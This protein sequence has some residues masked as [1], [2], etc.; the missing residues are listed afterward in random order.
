MKGGLTPESI[1]AEAVRHDISHIFLHYSTNAVAYDTLLKTIELANTSNIN[2]TFIDPVPAWSDHIPKQM[3]LNP[4]MESDLYLTKNQY[5]DINSKL[6]S[7]LNDI[8][9][10]NFRRIPIVDL[11]CKPQ[12]LYKSTDGLPFYY[13]HFH[14]TLTG[15]SVLRDTLDKAVKNL[16]RQIEP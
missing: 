13:D 3:L 15:S 9:Y 8:P 1:I 5:L 7:Q 4:D 11:F 6:F 16:S 10:D 2:I 14:L 12:C